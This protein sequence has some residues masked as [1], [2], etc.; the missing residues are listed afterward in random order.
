MTCLSSTQSTVQV[1]TVNTNF[2]VPV[3]IL[4]S[5]FVFNS[6]LTNDKYARLCS[7]FSAIVPDC[8]IIIL[9][10]ICKDR[11]F[12]SHSKLHNKGSVFKS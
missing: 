4:N 2:F 7:L 10:V 9:T 3:P 8:K 11:L 6:I 12:V 1:G 5:L